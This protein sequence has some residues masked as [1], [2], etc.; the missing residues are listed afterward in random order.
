M[1]LSGDED[2]K[3]ADNNHKIKG[4]QNKIKNIS[5]TKNSH[6]LWSK[7]NE[8]NTNCLVADS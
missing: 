5:L 1:T 6:S 3:C 8:V 2:N 7:T 4:Q